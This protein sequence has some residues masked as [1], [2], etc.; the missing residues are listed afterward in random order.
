M[1]KE[2]IFFGRKHIKDIT[3]VLGVEKYATLSICDPDKEHP[4]Y[5]DWI[6]SKYKISFSDVKEHQMHIRDKVWKHRADIIY[7]SDTDIVK[8]LFWLNGVHEHPNTF[9]LYIS[10]EHGLHRAASFARF[11]SAIDPN[12]KVSSPVYVSTD[13][14]NRL[15]SGQIA[16]VYRVVHDELKYRK[17]QA[18]YYGHARNTEQTLR[19]KADNSTV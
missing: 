19:G 9:I 16:K 12:I 7:P 5:P 1:I 6:N 13:W 3:P 4:E 17:A 18:T 14:H 2:V 15:L 11:L 10:S 8:V